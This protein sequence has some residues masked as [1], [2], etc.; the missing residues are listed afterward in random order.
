VDSRGTFVIVVFR[1]CRHT[2]LFPERL[3]YSTQGGQHGLT[4]YQSFCG[5]Q[6]CTV[7]SVFRM[8][9]KYP[10]DGCKYVGTRTMSDKHSTGHGEKSICNRWW[11]SL[12]Y[13]L[14]LLYGYR[15]FVHWFRSATQLSNRIN[16]ETK[17]NY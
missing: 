15:C 5:P 16:M 10:I 7:R 12:R 14:H 13:E 4:S 6:C 1:R 8:H 2:P 11:Y 3:V 9:F 17:P